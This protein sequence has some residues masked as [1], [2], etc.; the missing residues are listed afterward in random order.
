MTA[1]GSADPPATIRA[2]V[3]AVSDLSHVAVMPGLV[4]AHT[5]LELSYLR[6]DIAPADGFMSWVRQVLAARSSRDARDAEIHLGIDR[7][8]EESIACGTAVVGDIS[9]TLAA[10]SPLARSQLAGVLFYE[11]IGFG[12]DPQVVIDQA[13]RALATVPRSDRLHLSFAAHAPYSVSPALF[14]TIRRAAGQQYSRVRSVHLAESPEEV[15]FIRTGTGPWRSVLHELGAWN[16]D[17]TAPGVSPVQYLDDIGFLDEDVLVVHGVQTTNEDLQRLA[18]RKV[19]LV[20]CPRSNLRTGVGPPPLRRFYASGVRV[21]I[22]TDSLASA[23][24]LNLF[25]EL[26]AIRELTPGVPAATLLAS[27]T[28]IGAEAL[29]LGHDYGTIEPGRRARLIAVKV[30]AS[31][32][33]VEE[34][35]VSGIDR[36]Q[37]QWLH[38]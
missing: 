24:D 19:T 6:G 14:T 10:G 21:A 31:T 13:R 35:L 7:A 26:K 15:E 5:H 38:D 2:A 17:W 11:L 23:P 1:V 8:I 3:T 4:N 36:G 20:T 25:A 28:R 37:I 33:D 22:G 30:P 34:Y 12:A 9:N 18:R 29:G 27:A 32:T 16:P